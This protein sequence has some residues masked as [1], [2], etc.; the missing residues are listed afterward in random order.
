MKVALGSLATLAR[1]S[2]PAFLVQRRRR[3]ATHVMSHPERVDDPLL[4]A[5]ARDGIVV[6]EGWHAGSAV[7][8][9]VGALDEVVARVWADTAPPEWDTVRYPDD[10]IY[11]VRGVSTL[12][13]EAG[14]LLRVPSLIALAGEYLG[15]AVGNVVDYVDFKPDVGVHDDTTVPHMD[16][17]WPQIKIF[18]LLSDVG[19]DNAPLVYWKGSHVPARWRLLPDYL[20]FAGTYFGSG[21][22][23]PPH[24]LREVEADSGAIC[25]TV[26][27]GGAGTVVVMD[28]RGFHRASNLNAGRRLQL[29]E[30]IS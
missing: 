19:P 28:T 20:N 23:C 17:C 22:V 6:L 30:V 18:T 13:P 12:V 21:G 5:L 27:T 9:A 3:L 24:V 15:H 26:V 25:K 16:G 11:R 7:A 1:R 14:A 8:A 10:G 2:P 4:A 29:V